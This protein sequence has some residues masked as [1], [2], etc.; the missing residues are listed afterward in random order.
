V[1]S[2]FAQL[3]AI[4]KLMGLLKQIHAKKAL[5]LPRNKIELV[6]DLSALGSMSNSELIDMQLFCKQFQMKLDAIMK[7]ND[8]ERSLLYALKNGNSQ[9]RSNK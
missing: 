2:F 3:I 5:P 8:E 4:Y 6:E 1:H 7:Y 9:N